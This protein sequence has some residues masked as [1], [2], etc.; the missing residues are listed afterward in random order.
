M[1]EFANLTRAQVLLNYWLADAVTPEEKGLAERL[2]D[3][4]LNETSNESAILRNLIG[5]DGMRMIKIKRG[6]VIRD[7][8][9]KRKQTKIYGKLTPEQILEIYYA[10]GK[11]HRSPVDKGRRAKNNVGAKIARKFRVS[12]AT[13]RNIRMFLEG[14]KMYPSWRPTPAL[15]K[16]REI[17]EGGV[18]HKVKEVEPIVKERPVREIVTTPEIEVD[19]EAWEIRFLG[20]PLI[21]FGRTRNGHQN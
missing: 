14:R 18:Q 4:V 5:E 17:L 11:A 21:S 12:T 6:G 9:E 16:A 8:M 19:G 15:I 13:V 10:W 1:N 7:K 2:V 20:R 3:F